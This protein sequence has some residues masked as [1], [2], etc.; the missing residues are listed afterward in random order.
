MMI[1][2]KR[3][4]NFYNVL[5]FPIVFSYTATISYLLLLETLCLYSRMN[6]G[7][8]HK[9]HINVSKICEAIGSNST[10]NI[11]FIMVVASLVVEVVT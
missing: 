2:V 1:S 8:T 11:V 6:E 3:N 7:N 9:H 4:K 5:R 10:L